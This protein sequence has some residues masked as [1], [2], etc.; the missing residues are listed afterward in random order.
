[1]H[2][3]VISHNEMLNLKQT[4]QVSLFDLSLNKV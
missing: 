1:M 2:F 3:L 4:Q